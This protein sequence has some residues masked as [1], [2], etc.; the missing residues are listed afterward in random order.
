MVPSIE[1][2]NDCFKPA[3]VSDDLAT[4]HT[5]AHSLGHFL[6]SRSGSVPVSG[7]GD[8]EREEAVA[9]TPRG[10]RG[11]HLLVARRRIAGGGAQAADAQAAAG[12]CARPWPDSS[13]DGKR[14]TQGVGRDRFGDRGLFGTCLH[15]NSTALVESV[16]RAEMPGK[17]HCWA[18]LCAVGPQDVQEL[19]RGGMT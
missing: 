9:R 19:G 2:R 11:A 5:C 3:R 10:S 13:S 14:M 17:S 4:D 1:Q 12:W 16:V 8:V 15:T 7:E 18:A 6:L